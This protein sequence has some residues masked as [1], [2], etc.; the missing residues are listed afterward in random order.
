MFA[1]VYSLL[2]FMPSIRTITTRRSLSSF[3]NKQGHAHGMTRF[4]RPYS[5]EL[6]PQE[7]KRLKRSEADRLISVDIKFSDPDHPWN[8]KY[9][10]FYVPK[11]E[12]LLRVMEDDMRTADR[13]EKQKETEIAWRKTLDQLALAPKKVGRQRWVF[14]KHYNDESP[15]LTLNLFGVYEVSKNP[16]SPYTFTLKQIWNSEL[17]SFQDYTG[18]DS[19]SIVKIDERFVKPGYGDFKELTPDLIDEI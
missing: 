10:E 16:Q 5:M 1:C 7:F 14:L 17:Q 8:L 9:V 12:R 13:E 4:T 18:H 6:T 3:A 15:G 2:S 11:E 19:W